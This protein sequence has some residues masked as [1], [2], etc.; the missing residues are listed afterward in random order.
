VEGAMAALVGGAFHNEVT[1]FNLSGD[2]GI[3][4]LVHFAT[5][6]LNG[7]DIRFFVN[8]NLYTF[9]ESDG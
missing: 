3:E 4:L 5:G 8:F 9:R 7:D 2:I 6:A 1:V